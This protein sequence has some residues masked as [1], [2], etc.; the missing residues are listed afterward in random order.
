MDIINKIASLKNATKIKIEDAL[1]NN[2][3][4]FIVAAAKDLD[5]LE[6]L[7]KQAEDIKHSLEQFEQQNKETKN[8]DGYSAP[9]RISNKIRLQGDKTFKQIGKEKRQAFI[10][11]A[12]KKGIILTLEKG[13]LYRNNSGGLVGIAYASERS[14]NRW[15]LGLPNKEYNTIVFICENNF[16][17]KTYFIF[18]ST[19]CKKYKDKFSTDKKRYQCKFNISCK[20]GMYTLTIPDIKPIAINEYINKFDNLLH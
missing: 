16:L 14:E 18:P 13:L 11:E 3:T 4:G 5:L 8:F 19:F 20:N 12:N 17:K 2:Q 10:E 6:R 7:E 9:K 15:F 1:K